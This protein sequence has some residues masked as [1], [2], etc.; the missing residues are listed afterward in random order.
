MRSIE[1]TPA[2]LGPAEE[3]DACLHGG[4]QAGRPELG[5]HERERGL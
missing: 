5:L 2:V 3:G 4:L 1:Q